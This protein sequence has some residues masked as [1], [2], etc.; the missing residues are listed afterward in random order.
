MGQSR[1][2]DD[3]AWESDGASV[4]VEDTQSLRDENGNRLPNNPPPGP[5]WKAKKA[6][7][8]LHLNGAEYVVLACLIDR[9]NQQTGLCYPSEEFI[10]GWTCRPK[11]TVERAIA[12][13]RGTRLIQVIDRGTT[14]N[15]YVINW[16]PLFA[17]FT[18]MERFE[19]ESKKRHAPK[20]AAHPAKSGGTDL[21]KVAAKP[22]K[23]EPCN[24]NPR[25]EVVHPLSAAALVSFFNEENKGIQREPVDRPLP[26]S[27]SP[28]FPEGSR[29][30]AE[31]AI[32]ASCSA[33][34]WDHLTTATYE[35]AVA[36]EMEVPG[37]GAPL[38]KTA[39]MD[40]WRA[41]RKGAVNQ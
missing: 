18:E 14:S 36:A 27:Q 4:N 34:D 32:A 37:S 1:K 21:Q 22:L 24:K 5:K 11:R 7:A 28:E 3:V 16:R 15:R 31:T 17:A 29:E 33:F 13:L 41:K 10:A 9:A 6:L 25:H 8:R 39:S 2:W 20:V 26:F 35:A 38:A 19:T 30:D 12:S 23:I 40:A